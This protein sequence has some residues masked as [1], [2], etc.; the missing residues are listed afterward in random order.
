MSHPCLHPPKVN[1]QVKPCGAAL[2]LRAWLFDGTATTFKTKTRS[3]PALLRR[4]VQ[5]Y[6]HSP[7]QWVTA[8]SVTSVRALIRIFQ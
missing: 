6:V 8:I 7:G 1:A 5:E 3:L 4:N 2:I